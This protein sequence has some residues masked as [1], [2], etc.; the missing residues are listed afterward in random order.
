MIRRALCLAV[1]AALWAPAAP[2]SGVTFGKARAKAA[3][4]VKRA[5]WRTAQPTPPAPVRPPCPESGTTAGTL[6]LD[7]TSAARGERFA[8]TLRNTGTTCLTYGADYSF[9][10][11]RDGRWEPAGDPRPV[12]AWAAGLAPGESGTITGFVWEELE[13][14]RHRVVKEAIGPTERVVVYAELDIV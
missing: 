7:R 1:A 13:P 11:W 6:A 4:Q 8:I 3:K 12:P 14:G 5:G 9:E 2:A 10:R